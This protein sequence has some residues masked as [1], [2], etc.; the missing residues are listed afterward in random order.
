MLRTCLVNGEVDTQVFS[1]ESVLRYSAPSVNRGPACELRSPSLLRSVRPT[2]AS[3][4]LRSVPL[5]G[6]SAKAGAPEH[7]GDA[8]E[9]HAAQRKQLPLPKDALSAAV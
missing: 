5:T 8:E 7:A 9:G 4:G 3:G 2:L 1:A 6:A